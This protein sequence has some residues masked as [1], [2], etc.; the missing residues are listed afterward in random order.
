MIDPIHGLS[1]SIQ[2]K[3]G[4]YAL[5]LGSGVSRASGIPT[6]W[7]V[8]LDLV[9]KLAS[10]YDGKAEPDPETWYREKFGKEPNYSDLLDALAKTPAE[11]QQLLRS[12]WEPNDQEREEGAKQPT[13][14]HRAIAELAAQ[15][16]FKVIITTNFDRL[17]ENALRD[18]DVVPTVLSSPDHVKGMLPLI[19]TRCCVFKIHGDYLDTRI[20]NTPT[21]L[22]VYPPEFD[23]LLD[24]IFDE[25]GL[26]I[27]GWSATWDL[28]L[29]KAILRA[30]SR[31]FTTFWTFR[32][33]PN[34][35]GQELITHRDAQVISIKDADTFFTS[36]QQLVQSLEDISKPHPLST[37]AAVASLRR[38]LSN[39]QDQI[40][41]SELID[42]TLNRA[43]EAISGKTFNEQTNPTPR[44]ATACVRDYQDIYSTLLAM[45]PVGGFWAKEDHY[46]VWQQALKRLATVTSLSHHQRWIQLQRYPGT[47]L[48][49][50]LGLGAVAADRLEFLG[51]IFAT[52]IHT[53]NGNYQERINQ[54]AVRLL[55]AS[56][57]FGNNRLVAQFLEGMEKHNVPLN[58]W[59]QNELWQ[60]IKPLIHNED[61]YNY[62]FDKLEI[63][64]ALSYIYHG[65]AHDNEQT[66]EY[67]WAPTG[68]FAYYRHSNYKSILQEI[69]ESILEFQDESPLV[70]SNIFGKTTK[71]CRE[72]LENFKKFVSAVMLESLR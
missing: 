63:L 10:L 28:A 57:L 71:V 59:L 18:A 29:R 26:I 39:P 33:P 45:A 61:Q 24:L 19:H 25:F 46:L 14:A 52:P 8:T 6:G 13:A 47:L 5:L 17:M 67:S 22:K 1:F 44:N 65:Y 20:L 36:V 69:E 16:F 62:I 54:A 9:R 53:W 35:E 34:N 70:K 43:D 23:Q 15:G 64:M 55:P 42:D 37:E 31:R 56:C 7:E 51:R 12:Y 49:Y 2:A 68:A 41:L 32:D 66:E 40:R 27:C 21:E 4:I 11:R 58:D 48:F 50:A 30:S 60:Y 72:I 38:Y 3:R